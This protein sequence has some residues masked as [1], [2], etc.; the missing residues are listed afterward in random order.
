MQEQSWE[1]HLVPYLFSDHSCVFCRST[2]S[3]VFSPGDIQQWMT[4]IELNHALS[5]ELCL[6]EPCA[7]QARADHGNEIR[8]ARIQ[9]GVRGAPP[10]DYEPDLPV[11]PWSS[12]H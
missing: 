2:S 10:P 5:T 1:L 7:W 9:P 12:P 3:T 8:S 6:R 4:R 11:H